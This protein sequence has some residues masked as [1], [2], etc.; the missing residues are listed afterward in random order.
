MG[1]LSR[2]FGPKAPPVM[3]VHVD[4]GNYGDEVLRSDLPVMLDVWGPGC[5]PCKHLEPIV[6][7]LAGRYRGRVKVAEMN[8]AEAPR[9]A[10]RLG[11][12]GTPTVLFLRRRRE[13]ER[14][15]GF[16]GELYLEE[17]IESELLGEAPGERA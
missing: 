8:A 9:T 7:R 6:V 3:P 13:V 4:D 17:I 15:V 11:V 12:Q 2:L 14:V 5:T 10:A 16:R 1:I